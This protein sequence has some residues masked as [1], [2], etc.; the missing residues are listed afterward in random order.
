MVKSI[1][2]TIINP[3]ITEFIEELITTKG[4]IVASKP[5]EIAARPIEEYENC[6]R[7]RAIDKFDVAVYLAA[8]NFYLNE[9]DLQAHRARGALIIYADAEVADKIFKAAGL[10]V[11]YDEDDES[12]LGLCGSLCQLVADTLKERLYAAGYPNL[13]LGG[14]SV[15]KNTILGG[16]EFCKGQEEKQEIS[17]Y[18]LKHKALVI[19]WTM[20]PMAKR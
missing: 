14:M 9:A 2:P 1:E 5:F 13:V 19:D 17:F 10:D 6:M 7:V 12:M 18:F 15:F 20:A 4:G 11:P 3:L 16:V 8:V